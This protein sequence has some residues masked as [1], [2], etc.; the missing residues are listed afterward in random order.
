MTFLLFK[1][2]QRKEEVAKHVFDYFDPGYPSPLYPMMED[3]LAT[4]TKFEIVRILAVNMA[5]FMK[6]AQQTFNLL[7]L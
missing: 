3:Y 1:E 2:E 6:Q 4:K 7:I 5:Y